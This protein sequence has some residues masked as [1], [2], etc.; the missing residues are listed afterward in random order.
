MGCGAGDSSR[1]RLLIPLSEL[2]RPSVRTFVC[3]RRYVTCRRFSH[4]KRSCCCGTRA[5]RRCVT[6]SCAVG[7]SGAPSRE[8]AEPVRPRIGLTLLSDGV[9][10]ELKTQ[11]VDIR[12]TISQFG[13]QW[14]RQFYSKQGGV[15]ALNEWVFLLGGLDQGVAIPSLSW[16]VGL[17]TQEGAEFGVGPNVTP[18]GVALAVAAGVTIRTGAMNIPMNFAVVPT[19][20]GTRV[21]LLTGFTLRR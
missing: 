19:K 6:A 1:S 17:R 13:W 15:T 11:G 10:N 9:V 21:T 12:P 20:A 2:F 16:L 8:D 18:A 3:R 7:E 5:R 14:E 4:A